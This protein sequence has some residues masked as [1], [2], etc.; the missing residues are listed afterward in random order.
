MLEKLLHLGA[1]KDMVDYS[2]I[3]TATIKFEYES[4]WA[5]DSS[6]ISRIK[7]L[8]EPSSGGPAFSDRPSN[9]SDNSMSSSDSDNEEEGDE[10]EGDEE[11]DDE[12][13]DYEEEEDQ[14]ELTHDD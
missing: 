7:R 9:E 4:S 1:D 13:E 12:E 11:E 3:A 5:R 6:L 10:E 2:G 14:D 8:I